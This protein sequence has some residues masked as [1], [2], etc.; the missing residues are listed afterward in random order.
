MVFP[1]KSMT[2]IELCEAVRGLP[3]DV[4][5][6]EYIGG[7]NEDTANL[8]FDIADLKHTFTSYERLLA[9]AKDVDFPLPSHGQR[10]LQAAIEEAEK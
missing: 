4:C 7:A 1:D 2:N 3:D 6:V 9:A 10:E 5:L 8:P